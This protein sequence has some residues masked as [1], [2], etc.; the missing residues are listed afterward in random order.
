VKLLLQ[1]EDWGLKSTAKALFSSTTYMP[2][3]DVTEECNADESSQ[4]SQ[5]IGVLRWAV[6]LGCLEIYIE[7]ALLSQHLALP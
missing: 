7:V 5:F 6:E 2:E 3:M 1:E 4:Y